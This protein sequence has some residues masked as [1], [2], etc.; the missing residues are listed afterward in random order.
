MSDNPRLH[1]GHDTC[2]AAVECFGLNAD[3]HHGS[4]DPE[5]RANTGSWVITSYSINEEGAAP[6]SFHTDS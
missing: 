5:E 1:R 4:T 6:V 3:N 2:A